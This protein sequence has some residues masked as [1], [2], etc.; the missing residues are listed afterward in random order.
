MIGR[1]FAFG[2]AQAVHRG[3]GE[4]ALGGQTQ[5]AHERLAVHFVFVRAFGTGQ[6]VR[7][8]TER[9]R[10]V[11]GGQTT[12]PEDLDEPIGVRRVPPRLLRFYALRVLTSG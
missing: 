10:D 7:E 5:E 11:F 2:S 4:N 6:A 9:P 12:R 3:R 1:P 8:E